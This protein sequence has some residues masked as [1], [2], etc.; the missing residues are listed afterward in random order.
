MIACRWASPTRLFV[1]CAGAVIQYDFVADAT[2]PGGVRVVP[3][4]ITRQPPRKK[5]DPQAPKTVVSP[6]QVLPA[7]GVWSDL[8][9][10]L[11]PGGDHGGTHGTIYVATSGNPTTPAMDT[12][13]WFN[14]TDRWHATNLRNDPDGIAAPAYAVAVDNLDS[15]VVYVGTAVGVWKGTLTIGT[16]KWKWTILSN[17]LPE[18]SVQDL[19]IVTAGG[20]RLLR[21]AVQARGVWELDLKAPAAAQTFVRTHAYDTRRVTPTALVDPRQALPNTS[22]SW[23]ASPDI[24]VRPVQG[25][26]PPNPIG[27][28][29]NGNSPDPYGLWVFQTAIR[30]KPQ[31]RACKANGQ[32]TP[33]FE[34][35]LRTMTAGR[36]VTQAIWNAN[37]GSGASFPN[38]YATRGTAHRRPKPT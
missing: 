18:A 28:P 25:T 11:Q 8:A 37:V 1:L 3:T 10:H 2:A 13:W 7:I 14:G 6:G 12:L 34:A 31:G 4:D 24:R 36:R 5:E 38:A 27:L 20:A 30:T 15:N 16:P 23:H 32:W 19:T 17:G 21:A 26:K 9:I 33:S 22:L 29:W 35:I